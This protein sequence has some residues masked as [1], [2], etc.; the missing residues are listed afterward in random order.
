MLLLLSLIIIIT[1][2]I[3]IYT[4]YCISNFIMYCTAIFPHIFVHQLD[5]SW[6]NSKLYDQNFGRI[7]TQTNERLVHL[8][9]GDEPNLESDI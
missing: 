1:I 4:Q 6:L 8:K 2:T 3:I 5:D 7:F 9:M